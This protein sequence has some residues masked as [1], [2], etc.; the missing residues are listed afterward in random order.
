MPSTNTHLEK[1]TPLRV[2]WAGQHLDLRSAVDGH[3]DQHIAKH[4]R[5]DVLLREATVDLCGYTAACFAMAANFARG[6][7]GRESLSVE[8][9]GLMVAAIHVD[10][11]HQSW[12]ISG[13]AGLIFDAAIA[14]QQRPNV[15][16]DGG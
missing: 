15:T 12:T 14:M 10:W 3:A 9:H 13:G 6:N 8:Y 5:H 11:A 1:N 4:L 2:L 16:L 7:I